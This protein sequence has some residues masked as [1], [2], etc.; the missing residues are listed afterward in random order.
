MASPGI[1]LNLWDSAW[2]PTTL[3]QLEPTFPWLV[4]TLRLMCTEET[5]VLLCYKKRR[6]AD[7]RFFVLL[8]Q[9]FTFDHVSRP[10]LR[11]TFCS[12]AS[13]KAL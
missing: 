12:I 2:S 5:E 11:S 13:R 4:Q 1:A 10:P 7:K 6:K 8:K 3:F 9:Y